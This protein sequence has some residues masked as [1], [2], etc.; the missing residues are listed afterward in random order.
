MAEQDARRGRNLEGAGGGAGRAGG[1]F[2]FY[3]PRSLETT[4]HRALAGTPESFSTF[5]STR[6]GSQGPPREFG[7]SRGLPGP[8][9]ELMVLPTPPQP[10]SLHGSSGP[11][12]RHPPRPRPGAQ[13]AGGKAH[14]C[15]Q[16]AQRLDG[17][18]P[19][20]ESG[21]WEKPGDHVHSFKVKE[22][23]EGKQEEAQIYS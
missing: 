22:H 3:F 14:P 17:A 7:D 23:E 2:R 6:E 20:P 12:L 13:G 16:R 10:P 15:P 18:K 4:R 1:R 9:W 21:T 19:G 11:P 5:E 8:R